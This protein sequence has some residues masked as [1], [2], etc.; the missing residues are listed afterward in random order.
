[1]IVYHPDNTFSVLDL[2]LMT[3]LRVNSTT[4]VS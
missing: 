2:L 3:E 4:C 1:M